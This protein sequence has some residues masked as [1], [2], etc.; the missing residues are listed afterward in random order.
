M[1]V[2]GWIISYLFRWLPHSVETGLF[3][4]GNPDQDSPVIVTANFSLTVKLVK[5]E[6]EFE[7]VK[8]TQRSYK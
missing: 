2:G 3:P 1:G 5:E 8:L 6:L 7:N 4:I